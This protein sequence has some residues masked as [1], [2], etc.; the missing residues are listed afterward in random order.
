ME[1]NKKEIRIELGA[2]KTEAINIQLDNKHALKEM[3][4]EKQVEIM[5]HCSVQIKE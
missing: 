3:F 1:M 5:G 4:A 2:F